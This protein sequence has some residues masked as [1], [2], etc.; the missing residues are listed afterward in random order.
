[1]K[2]RILL[3]AGAIALTSLPHAVFAEGVTGLFISLKVNDIQAYKQWRKTTRSTFQAHNC[4]PYRSGKLIGGNGTLKWGDSD[5]FS[6]MTCKSPVLADLAAKGFISKL[7]SLTDGLNMT[8]GR[9][10]LMSD[11][12]PSKN[13]EYLIKV[14]HFNNLNASSRQRDLANIDSRARGTRN[15]WIDDAILE[16]TASVGIIRPDN[17]TFLYYPK[18]GQGKAFRENNPDLMN[19]IG[20]FNQVHVERVTYL[21]AQVKTGGMK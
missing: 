11:K 2:K 5:R 7:S 3:L 18:V 1:M 16:P 4:V 9:L 10:K 19:E 8:E 13:S 21:A 15:A 14:S 12:M 6:L 17:L 20:R